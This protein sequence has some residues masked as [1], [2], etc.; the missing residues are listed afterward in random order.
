MV[1][2]GCAEV[3]LQWRF[4]FTSFRNLDCNLGVGARQAQMKFCNGRA[5]QSQGN[6][7]SLD[8]ITREPGWL[9]AGDLE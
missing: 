9:K 5:V 2:S 1:R 8:R 4:K 3:G 7:L 6:F